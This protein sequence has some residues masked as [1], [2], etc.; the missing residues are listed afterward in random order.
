MQITLFQQIVLQS[1]DS[2]EETCT[3]A[4]V[5]GVM[6]GV[7]QSQILWGLL[8]VVSSLCLTYCEQHGQCQKE[9][10]RI[11]SCDPVDF[12]CKDNKIR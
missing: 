5:E 9:Y 7:P 3:I 11:H 6:H 12:E 2:R 4:I 10:P 8:V 1:G